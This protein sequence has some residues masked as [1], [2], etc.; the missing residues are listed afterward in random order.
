MAGEGVVR[1]DLPPRFVEHNREDPAWLGALPDLL[2][3]LARRWSLTLDPPFPG[4]AF[5]YVAPAFRADGACV[6]K[7]SRHVD[8]TRSELAALRLWDGRGAARVLDAD[9]EVGALL[10]E[11][12]EPG[13]TLV[14][15][16][17]RDDDAATRVAADLLRK[18][19]FPVPDQSGLRPLSRW[20]DAFDR[21]RAALL[22]GDRGFP[23]A[24][25]ERADSLRH[26]LLASTHDP[27]VLHGDLH[28]GNILR[29]DRE[30]WLAIDPKGLRG[31][32]YFDVCQFLRNPRPVSAEINRRRLD[33][34]T[35]DLGLDRPR[36]AA[37]C[38]VHAVLDALWDFEDGK[39]W[40]ATI[41]YAEETQTY[42]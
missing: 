22:R 24:L 11:R 37:W 34:L 33:I 14:E 39:D 38:F 35:D 4:I 2:Q 3:R 31:D 15:V 27:V 12:V 23:A 13:G 21:N 36:A 18:M 40:A 10:V 6:I 42:A 9:L 8:E 26:D 16:A 30:P 7:I 28:H 32:R 20:C 19:W 5:N 25:F 29:A 1:P 17:D 41:A